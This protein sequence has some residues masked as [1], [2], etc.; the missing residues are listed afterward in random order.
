[1]IAGEMTNIC[2]NGRGAEEEILAEIFLDGSW[3]GPFL[4]STASSTHCAT[5]NNASEVQTPNA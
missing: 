2:E 4:L 5:V 3:L 1:M